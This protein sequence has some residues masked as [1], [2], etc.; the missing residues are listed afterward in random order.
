MDDVN[1][2]PR[3]K[4]IIDV[5][6]KDPENLDELKDCL[7]KTTQDREN[8]YGICCGLAWEVRYSPKILNTHSSPIQG[9]RNFRQTPDLPKSYPGYEGRIWLRYNKKTKRHYGFDHID[10]FPVHT[11]SGGAG[12]YCGPWKALSN[13]YDKLSK[14][15]KKQVGMFE[16]YSYNLSFYL[17]DWPNLQDLTFHRLVNPNTDI[18]LK[19]RFLWETT[20]AHEQATLIEQL[21]ETL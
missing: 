14:A 8:S 10:H 4:A 18:P 21:Y 3:K 9:V 5:F 2:H 11:G 13:R 19:H 6:G 16:L 12:G 17:M 1:Q 20:E 7:I 15:Q